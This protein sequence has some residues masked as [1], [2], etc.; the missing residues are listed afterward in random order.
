MKGPIARATIQTTGVFALRLLIQGASLLVV[1]RMLGPVAYG[2]FAGVAALALFI[3]SMAAFGFPLLL[4]RAVARD[5]ERREAVLAFALPSVLVMST[6]MLALFVPAC[7]LLFTSQAVDAGMVL[8]IGASEILLQ[9]LLL[10]CAAEWHGRGQITTAQLLQ[11]VPLGLRLL[12]AVTAAC[13]WPSAPLG[14][15]VVGHLLASCGALVLALVLMPAGWPSP[16]HWRM[17]C[18]QEWFGAGGYAATEL[19]RNGPTELDKA[20]AARYLSMHDAGLYSA[21]AR[22]TGA[23]ALPVMAM[24]VSA[25]PRLFKESEQGGPPSLRLARWMALS[26]LAY[27]VSLS[28]LLWVAAPWLDR[29]L[30]SDYAG[31]SSVVRML[32]FA[33]PGF[34]LRLVFGN[35]LIALGRPWLRAGLE[36]AGIL[37]LLLAGSSL[38]RLYG[39]AGMAATVIFA[40]WAMAAMSAWCVWRHRASAMRPSSPDRL[41]R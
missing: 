38:G 35:I 41:G 12:A 31:V 33:V 17:P 2:A 21:G 34:S 24:V 28:A 27:G 10:I 20:M 1:S 39:E 36:G 15:Y 22:I 11:V 40:E 13:W 16:R 32:C 6:V 25:L 9:P 29:L 14:P 7:L 3:G 23:V 8:A 30:G 4:M 18:W 37:A 26:A 19:T 5:A